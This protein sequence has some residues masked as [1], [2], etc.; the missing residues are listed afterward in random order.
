MTLMIVNASDKRIVLLACS[1]EA[2][3]YPGARACQM[4]PHNVWGDHEDSESFDGGFIVSSLFIQA[5]FELT[6]ARPVMQ[7]V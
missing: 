5:D 6:I 2:L 1:G 4:D 7:W 3:K